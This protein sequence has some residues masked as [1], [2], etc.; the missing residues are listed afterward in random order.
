MCVVLVQDIRR[1]PKK[2]KEQFEAPTAKKDLSKSTLKSS[3]YKNI[4]SKV[5]TNLRTQQPDEQQSKTVCM[6]IHH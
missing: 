2:L 5:D 1:N 3:L 6:H 4:N